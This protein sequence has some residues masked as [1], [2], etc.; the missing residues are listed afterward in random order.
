MAFDGHGVKRLAA[1]VSCPNVGARDLP[2]LNV[3]I[4]LR[5]VSRKRIGGCQPRRS[6]FVHAA[7]RWRAVSASCDE[8]SCVRLGFVERFK[9]GNADGRVVLVVYPAVV[10]HQ[11][12]GMVTE[13]LPSR[14]EKL[15][16]DAYSGANGR[17]GVHEGYTAGIR[18]EVH[19][20]G[21]AFMTSN[22]NHFDGQCQDLRHDLSNSRRGP[23]PDVRCSGMNGDT[24]VHVHLNVHR[25]VWEILRIPVNGQS[26]TRNEETATNADA[27]AER[28]LA[29][30]CVPL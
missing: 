12:V 9:V 26:G 15:I 21:I 17:V 11:H 29:E 10:E 25:G 3:N 1:I 7:H 8:G 18:T 24:T 19:R 22:V 6:A 30:F 14:L 2:G 4:N 20:A 16:P 27:F 13:H 23:L 28:K 5:Y